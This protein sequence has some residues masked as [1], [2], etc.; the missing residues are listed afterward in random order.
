MMLYVK[1][2]MNQRKLR[3]CSKNIRDYLDLPTPLSPINQPIRGRVKG[4]RGKGRES[5]RTVEGE[6]VHKEQRG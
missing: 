6:G 1:G 3:S 5:G 4:G 2:E